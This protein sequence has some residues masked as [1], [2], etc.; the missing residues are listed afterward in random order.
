M[1]HT[2]WV[3]FVLVASLL[4]VPAGAQ[5]DDGRATGTESPAVDGRASQSRQASVAVPR[6]PTPQYQRDYDSSQGL[7]QASQGGPR[8]E[9]G[10]SDDTLIVASAAASQGSCELPYPSCTA[11]P[12]FGNACCVLLP[13]IPGLGQPYFCLAKDG[14]GFPITCIA[15]GMCP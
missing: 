9:L 13:R 10:K 11:G 15:S 3:G 7:I 12:Y 4:A 5:A 1:K 14:N 8:S 2:T 6:G